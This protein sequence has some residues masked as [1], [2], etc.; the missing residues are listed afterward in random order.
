MGGWYPG[1]LSLADLLVVLVV[2]DDPL[3]QTVIDQALC[4][5]GYEPAIVASGEEALTLLQ[6]NRQRYR[7]LVSDINLKGTID[8]WDVARQAREIDP[9]F[10]IVYMTGAA[11]EQWAS[12]GVPNSIL[13]TKPFAPAQLVTAISQLLNAGG[14]PTAPSP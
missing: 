12:H 9:S 4:D 11:A 6:G 13:L 5:G 2:E 1:D 8:G 3:I 14:Q 10:P 7:A